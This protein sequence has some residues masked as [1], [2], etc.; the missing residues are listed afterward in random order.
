MPKTSIK[1]KEWEP[2]EL[3]KKSGW[4]NNPMILSDITTAVNEEFYIEDENEFM[5]RVDI[6]LEWIS[7][8]YNF[9]HNG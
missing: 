8:R 4:K 9:V 7:Q 3:H 2:T 1:P 5:E 6:I